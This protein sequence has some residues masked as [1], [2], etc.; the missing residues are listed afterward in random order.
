[1]ARSDGRDYFQRASTFWIVSVTFGIS[2]YTVSSSPFL[3]SQFCVFVNT[4][5]YLKSFQKSTRAQPRPG[6]TFDEWFIFTMGL[7]MLL[8]R[9]RTGRKSSLSSPLSSMTNLIAIASDLC[10]RTAQTNAC[11]VHLARSF[12]RGSSDQFDGATGSCCCYGDATGGIPSLLLCLCACP[13]FFLCLR[14]ESFLF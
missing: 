5:I 7:K 1:M 13:C 3:E 10:E 4:P 8:R 6:G 9:P 2:L 11:K 12:V 14:T